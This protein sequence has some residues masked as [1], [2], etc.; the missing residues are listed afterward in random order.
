MKSWCRLY[1]RDGFEPRVNVVRDRTTARATDPFPPLQRTDPFPPL[2]RGGQGGWGGSL[3]KS[4]TTLP[5]SR[6]WEDLVT[7]RA[8]TTPPTP[9]FARGGKTTN[10]SQGGEKQRTL[11][12]GGK[13]N[14]PFARGG[15]TT[16]PSQGGEK[17]R[18]RDERA[19]C[20]RP[21]F[22]RARRKH[23][24]KEM[25]HV[26]CRGFGCHFSIRLEALAPDRSVHRSVDRPGAR[27]ERVRR[28]P[29]RPDDSGDR[30]PLEGLGRS[31]GRLGFRRAGGD[32]GR[33]GVRATA[34]GLL[35]RG[36]RL[37]PSGRNLSPYR[38]GSVS[39]RQR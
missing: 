36:P 15:K 38:A 35:R 32:D 21:N 37:R 1:W 6:A 29:R 30:H 7:D 8:V 28:R 13:N 33:S 31:P 16:N 4:K 17:E 22:H 39:G 14:E 23:P 20:S 18:N 19:A 9:P 10:P 27:R 3:W 24:P 2:R 5:A 34:A 11:R 12:K 26:S 25:D